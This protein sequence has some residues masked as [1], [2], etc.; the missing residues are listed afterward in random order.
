[1]YIKHYYNKSYHEESGNNVEQHDGYNDEDC[2][3][4]SNNGQ[5]Q[6]KPQA[7]VLLPECEDDPM[8]IVRQT[9]Q[10]SKWFTDWTDVLR[11]I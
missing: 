6:V 3:Q 7:H 2:G 5:R 11:Q 1:M 10:T 4:R 8:W 9:T